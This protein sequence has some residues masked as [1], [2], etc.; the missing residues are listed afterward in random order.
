M[1]DS[2]NPFSEY[3]FDALM[4]T[5]LNLAWAQ[6][7]ILIAFHLSVYKRVLSLLLTRFLESRYPNVAAEAISKPG[8]NKKPDEL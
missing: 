7:N 6:S 8:E 4:I 5:G 1:S 2:R 3:V